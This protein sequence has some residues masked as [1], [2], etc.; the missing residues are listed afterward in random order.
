MRAEIEAAWE[1]RSLLNDPVTI[2]AIEK[3]IE[4]IDKGLLRVAE[5]LENG[6]WQVNEWV[7]KEPKVKFEETCK[8]NRLNMSAVVRVMITDYVGKKSRGKQRNL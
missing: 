5:P 6:D 1:D 2:S 3:V 8:S 4:D 7:K